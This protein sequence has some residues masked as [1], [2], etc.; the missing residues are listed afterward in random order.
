[1]SREEE[2]RL[3]VERLAEEIRRGVREAAPHPAEN[4]GDSP[5]LRAWAGAERYS[6]PSVPAGAGLAFVKRT[7]LRILRIATRSQGTFNAK[8]LEG[9]RALERTVEELRRDLAEAERRLARQNDVL[10][11]RVAAVERA[12][13][14]ADS[15]RAAPSAPAPGITDGLYARFEEE[16]RGSEETVRERQEQY[17]D[18][19]RGAPGVVLDCG[20]GRGEFVSLLRRSGIEAEGIDANR[21]AAGIAAREGLPVAAGDAF[22]RLAGARG[23]LGG[24]SA[25]QFVE[26]LE[27]PA[28]REF[29]GR[30]F[31]ALAPGGRLLLET[32]NPDSLY[33][34]RAYRL[35]PTH[36]WP[37]PAATLSLFAR[38]AGFLQKEIRYLAPV[39]AE[40]TL[41][42]TG[43]NERKINRW[44]FGF[45]DYALF[46]ERPPA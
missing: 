29:L 18:F 2:D 35:D 23:S 19:F 22:E 11:A 12:G 42:E 3:S 36:R 32:I 45:Q 39:P 38:D 7:L 34:M 33:A 15:P 27:P 40:E 41:A 9:A 30:A 5:A 16:F 1:M 31:E 28:V 4:A 17:V 6:V 24:V 13:A 43:E 26:H 10:Q 14:P 25:L 44:L 46:A 8:L 37:V 20:C 21:V